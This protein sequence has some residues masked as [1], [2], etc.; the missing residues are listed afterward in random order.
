MEE[1]QEITDSTNGQPQL[2]KIENEYFFASEVDSW[3]DEDI[4]IQTNWL[5]DTDSIDSS[6]IDHNT[7]TIFHTTIVKTPPGVQ[8]DVVHHSHLQIGGQ[9]TLSSWNYLNSCVVCSFVFMWHKGFIP[10][11]CSDYNQIDHGTFTDNIFG[12]R[13]RIA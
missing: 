7:T 9:R 2:V 10:Q 12:S 4:N 3:Q 13:F 11:N 6:K 5:A 1:Y 8:N